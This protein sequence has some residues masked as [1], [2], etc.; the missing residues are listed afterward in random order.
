M[1]SISPSTTLE[2]LAYQLPVIY[3]AD[4]HPEYG[5]AFLKQIQFLY[6]MNVFM[7]VCMY[8]RVS[9]CTYVCFD[10]LLLKCLI[11]CECMASNLQ[12]F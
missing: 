6:W 5:A 1:S 4:I 3:I 8:G 10:A 12:R 9:T 2:S 11:E 7:Y